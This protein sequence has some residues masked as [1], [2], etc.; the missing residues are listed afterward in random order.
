[1]EAVA[2]WCGYAPGEA[3]VMEDDYLKATRR[4]RQVFERHFYGFEDGRA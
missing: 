3:S 2:R 1:M 4:A